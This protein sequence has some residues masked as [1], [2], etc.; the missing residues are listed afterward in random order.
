MRRTEE[1]FR[2]MIR[3]SPGN[4]IVPRPGD[5]ATSTQITALLQQAEPD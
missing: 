1:A 3:Q 5:Y 4:V 2:A